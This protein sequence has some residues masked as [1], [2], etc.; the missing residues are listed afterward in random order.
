MERFFSKV[1]KTRKCWNWIG[2][3]RGKNGYG[4]VKVEGKVI[5]VHKFA[6]MKLKGEI[7][8]NYFV[9][10]KCNNKLCVNPKHLILVTAKENY[11]NGVKRGT[12]TP[13]K[14]EHLKKHPSRSAYRNGCRCEGCKILHT[15][16]M[17]KYRAKDK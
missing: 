3:T 1:K 8:E 12:I 4:A 2:G 10:H 14:N 17:R 7:P 11:Q 13:P 16:A 6:Y 15:L 9:S 5:S